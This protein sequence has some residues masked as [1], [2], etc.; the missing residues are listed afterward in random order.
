V[1]HEPDSERLRPE[2]LSAKSDLGLY[3]VLDVGDR[4]PG[5]ERLFVSAFTDADGRSS[6]RRQAAR[7][8]MVSA[9]D[10]QREAVMDVNRVHRRWPWRLAAARALVPRPP[11]GDRPNG[12][13]VVKSVHCGFAL[14]WLADRI[15]IDA[16]AVTVRH[17]ANVIN[18][19][20]SFEWTLDNFP[21]SDVRVW[22]RF[23]PP[24]GNPGPHRPATYIEAAAWQFGLFANAILGS[25]Q[26]HGWPVVD[27]E[28]MIE[29]PEAAFPKLAEQLG[30]QWTGQGT[31]WLREHNAPGEG[32]QLKRVLADERGRWK[33]RLGAEDRAVVEGVLGR[34]PRIRE[35]WMLTSA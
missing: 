12:P 33:E 10:R 5:Y 13:R 19:W 35:R 20:R 26:R 3:P 34:F 27:H 21:W 7:R 16:V 31:D 22:E 29:N 32:Y 25:A 28:H 4:A 6:W 8:L 30:L 15:S 24:E 2:A 18:S 1:F 14:D 17:P 23:G 9:D 11:I